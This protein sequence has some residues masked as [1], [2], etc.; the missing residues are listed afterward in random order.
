MLMM[1]ISSM[2][3]V[4]SHGMMMFLLVENQ[5]APVVMMQVVIVKKILKGNVMQMAEPGKGKEQHVRQILVPRV[6]VL[7]WRSRKRIFLLIIWRI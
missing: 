5:Q 1:E 3:M 4:L 6:P 7:I 2:V